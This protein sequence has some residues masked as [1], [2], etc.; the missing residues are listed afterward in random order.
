MTNPKPKSLHLCTG[1][2]PIGTLPGTQRLRE[3]VDPRGCGTHTVHWPPRGQR[4]HQMLQATL[5]TRWALSESPH[6]NLLRPGRKQHFRKRNK[7]P[8]SC[9]AFA[10]SYQTF[11]LAEPNSK[12]LA[13]EEHL[14]GPPLIRQERAKKNVGKRGNTM[15]DWQAGTCTIFSYGNWCS[16]ICVRSHVYAYRHKW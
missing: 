14:S 15:N 9:S 11:E 4:V 6:T 13:K 12:S 5:T 1:C 7:V 10:V 8:S 16:Q 2:A 3:R